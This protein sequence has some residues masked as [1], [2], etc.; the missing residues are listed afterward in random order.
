M[1]WV[2]AALLAAGSAALEL[3]RE[4]SR[5]T[6]VTMVEM[7]TS[8]LTVDFI[9]RL[10]LMDDGPPP[11]RTGDFI[12]QGADR[13]TEIHLRR[14]GSNVSQYVTFCMEGLRNTIPKAVVH[15]QVSRCPP[16]SAVPLFPC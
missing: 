10:P 4:E 14:I 12:P 9:R 13:Y 5:R 8:F 3:F 15:C 11:K 16:P 2:Q 6:A 7:E 1:W